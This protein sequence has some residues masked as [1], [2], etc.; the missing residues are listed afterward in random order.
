MLWE[1]FSNH[2]KIKWLVCDGSKI[3]L[4][5]QTDCINYY[6]ETHSLDYKSLFV[7]EGNIK[8][9]KAFYE[10][11]EISKGIPKIKIGVDG[12]LCD[13]ESS[14]DISDNKENMEF[15][16]YIVCVENFSIRPALESEVTYK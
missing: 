13:I 4:P 12:I 9:I 1:D 3:K 15:S 8:W 5:I 14:C 11:Y 2:S 6:Y 10:K 7:L 16:G